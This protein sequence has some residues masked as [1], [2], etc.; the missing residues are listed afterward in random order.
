MRGKRVNIR[1]ILRDP[2]KRAALL[3]GAVRFLIAIGRHT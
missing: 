3:A 1:A 2:K